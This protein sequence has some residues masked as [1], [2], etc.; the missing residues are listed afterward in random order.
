[1]A[2]LRVVGA[3]LSLP[4]PLA[5]PET[6][7]YYFGGV[8]FM[9]E[10][11]R[12]R[13]YQF[14]AEELM[15]A[16]QL[17]T[18]QLGAGD[19]NMPRTLGSIMDAATRTNSSADHEQEEIAARKENEVMLTS[20]TFDTAAPQLAATRLMSRGIA[21]AYTEQ[22]TSIGTNRAGTA[23]AA[24]NAA[25]RAAR[26][27]TY[28]QSL[29][30]A[31]ANQGQMPCADSAPVPDGGTNVSRTVFGRTTIDLQDPHVRNAVQELTYNVTGFTPREP[32]DPAIAAAA[33]GRV[34]QLKDRK[35]LAKMNVA[36][37]L[38]SSVVGDR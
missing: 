16:L 26:M 18:V 35:Y 15:P 21:R 38:V 32:M 17:I 23:S 11:M 19:M 5:L 27:R 28:R 31:Q 3:Q 22:V 13:M 10:M 20:C 36:T 1:A 4:I 25:F 24:G 7:T 37:A 14:W 9:D 33:D 30:D 34:Q 2:L 6:N 29:C 8:R 12:G